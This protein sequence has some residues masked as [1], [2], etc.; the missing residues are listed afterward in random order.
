MTKRPTRSVQERMADL[1]LLRAAYAANLPALKAAL[2]A[3]AD[4][5][6][7][8]PYTGVSAL[9]IAAGMDNLPMA[10]FLADT[11]RAEFGPDG[12]GRWPSLIA[13]LC[14][15]SEATSDYIALREA[16]YLGYVDA[17]GTEDQAVLRQT[18]ADLSGPISEES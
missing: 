15:V 10:R 11:A 16:A 7:R 2:A 17:L 14:E 12:Q 9:H 6:T 1:D 13:A 8:D 5:N 4:V 18:V 3:G